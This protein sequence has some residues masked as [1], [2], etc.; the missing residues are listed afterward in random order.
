MP[1]IKLVLEYDGS[2]F[3]GWQRQP[4]QRTIQEELEKALQVVLR[5]EDISIVGS[6]RTDAGVHARAQVAH[7]TIEEVPD[8]EELKYSVSSLLKNELS[9]L[10]AEEV[11]EDF[12]ALRDAKKKTYC[13]HIL[14][15]DVPAVL[16][17][18][19]VWHFPYPLNIQRMQ[20]EAEYFIGKHDFS[21]F[22]A[23]GCGA[24]SPVRQIYSSEVLYADPHIE[25]RVTGAGFLKQMVRI[26]VG[27]LVALGRENP[28]VKT[29]KELL[30]LQDRNL[31]G[32]TAPAHGL[33][34]ERV[35]YN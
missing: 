26:M 30:E 7:F 15:R 21:S 10:D 17:Y 25:Y 34:L 12:H 28:R 13:Y 33:F 22:R 11:N 16:D 18:R 8:L 29:I 1:K 31:A 3:H 20:Q 23:S 14:N 4:G 2:G 27:T 35:Y 5:A 19:K 24:K 6:G 32:D 9:V